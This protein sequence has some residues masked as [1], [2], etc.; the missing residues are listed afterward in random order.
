MF[1]TETGLLAALGVVGL[2]FVALSIDAVVRV[3]RS[4]RA[5]DPVSGESPQSSPS[6]RDA[7]GTPLLLP[8]RTHSTEEARR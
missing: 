3:L 4:V 8:N 6:S 2:A 5:S 7:A 1:V